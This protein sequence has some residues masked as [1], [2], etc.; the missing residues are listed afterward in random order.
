MLV[1]PVLEHR[2]GQNVA[3]GQHEM[4]DIGHQ[5]QVG[6]LAGMGKE[7]DGLLGRRNR[8]HRRVQQQQ[9]APWWLGGPRLPPPWPQQRMLP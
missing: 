5:V 8:I 6:G 7:I 4:I 3:F 1:Q 9:R 2:L